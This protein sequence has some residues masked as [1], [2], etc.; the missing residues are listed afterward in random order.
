MAEMIKMRTGNHK[1]EWSE[2]ALIILEEFATA[3]VQGRGGACGRILPY[4]QK[5]IPLL[6]VEPRGYTLPRILPKPTQ[7]DARRTDR[8]F[9][10]FCPIQEP[11]PALA[12]DPTT[13]GAAFVSYS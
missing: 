4:V 6:E 1:A 8:L 12:R 11:A 5:I 2:D 9:L 13:R 3:K 10:S 7:H